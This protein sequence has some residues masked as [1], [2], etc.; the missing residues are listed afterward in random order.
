MWPQNKQ[1]VC[2]PYI[3]CKSTMD[4]VKGI[5]HLF[6]IRQKTNLPASQCGWKV[7]AATGPP[8]PPTDKHILCRRKYGDPDPVGWCAAG[9]LHGNPVLPWQ[10]AEHR[11]VC[12]LYGHSR[13]STGGLL[14]LSSPFST[15][16]SNTIL[17]SECVILKV[18]V[19]TN[20]L[21]ATSC[22]HLPP[23]LFFLSFQ[24]MF[25]CCSRSLTRSLPSDCLSALTEHLFST[26]SMPISP[27]AAPVPR[28]WL[29][30]PSEER[31]R[32]GS[33][34]GGG[35]GGLHREI[36]ERKHGGCC[37]WRELRD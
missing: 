6:G 15:Y 12:Q 3:Q 31:E 25:L 34:R 18:C 2:V 4:S 24:S 9:W 37:F 5:A 7:Q 20:D 10:A 14:A 35:E 23:S 13:S 32:G 19:R 17:S 8:E 36:P 30:N 16:S 26:A 21:Q 1:C 27:A 11:R 28:G 22:Q 29:K 33:H